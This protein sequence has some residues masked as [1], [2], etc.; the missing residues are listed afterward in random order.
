MNTEARLVGGPNPDGDYQ[1][2]MIDGRHRYL[3]SGDRN[4]VTYLG[5]QVLAGTGPN[6]RRMAAHVSD[7]DLAVDADGRFSFVLATEEPAAAELG[8]ATWVPVP[9]DASAVVVRQ[10]IADRAAETP[11][12]LVIESLDPPG[13]PSPP[14]DVQ[15]AGQLTAMAWTIAKLTTL[16]RTVR[17]ELLEQP[18][19]L[20]T[21]EAT[22]LGDDNTTPDNL[23]MMRTFR[24]AEE[25]S[26]VLDI[27]PPE[28]RCWSVTIENIWHECIDTRRRRTSLTN[29]GAIRE[30]DGTVRVVVSATEPVGP[31]TVNWLDTG[32]RHRG[33]VTLR[34]LDNPSPPVVRTSLIAPPDGGVAGHP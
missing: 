20:V 12:R 27:E 14:T 18:N 19:R 26:L 9:P 11:G 24:L 23:Y 25:E 28:T 34:W 22:E 4:S 5:F 3:V 15:V 21:A 32:G 16:H 33:F 2:A 17:P 1:L 6:P 8:G 31:G 30:E 29:A 7:R 13:R 10:Y